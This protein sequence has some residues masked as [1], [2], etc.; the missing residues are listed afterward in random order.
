MACDVVPTANGPFFVCG[1]FPEKRC[2]CGAP[3]TRECDFE[4]APGQTCDRGMCDEHTSE[5]G[6][7]TRIEFGL[8]VADTVDYCAR[9]RP[10]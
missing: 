3:A 10:R 1:D 7:V 2:W 8:G 9:H 6:V 4:V 5:R